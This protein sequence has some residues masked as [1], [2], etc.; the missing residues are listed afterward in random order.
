M[1]LLFTVLFGIPI[2]LVLLVTYRDRHLYVGG[3][4]LLTMCSLFLYLL[5]F[6]PIH[7]YECGNPC[8]VGCERGIDNLLP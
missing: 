6:V 1:T 3:L 2:V 4:C 8:P 7:Q 5:L